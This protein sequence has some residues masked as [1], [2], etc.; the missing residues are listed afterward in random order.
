M[1]VASCGGGGGL[2]SK[3]DSVKNKYFVRV[4]DLLGKYSYKIFSTGSRYSEVRQETRNFRKGGAL[5]E[6][7]C[8]WPVDECIKGSRD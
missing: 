2:T 5:G 1:Q 8:Q 6:P 3:S 4:C 7:V